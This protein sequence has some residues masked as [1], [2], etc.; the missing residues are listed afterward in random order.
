MAKGGYLDDPAFVSYL[1]YLKYWE[2]PEYARYVHY[3]HALYFLGQLQRPEFRR[4]MHNPRAV[5]HVHAQQ[6]YFWQSFRTSQATSQAG[7][8]IGEAQV[9][10]RVTT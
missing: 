9:Q 1:A 5:E 6:F 7:G 2:R 3:P 10:P 4:A 8:T